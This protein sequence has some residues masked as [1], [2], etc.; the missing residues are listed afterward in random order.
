MTDYSTGRNLHID[1][2][3]SGIVIG[4][5]PTGFIADQLLPVLSVDKQSNIYFK[6]NHKEGR[7]FVPDL[8]RRAPGTAARKVGFSVSSDTYYAK[9]YALASDW[10]VEDEVNADEALGWAQMHALNV[11]DRL[12]IDYELRVAAM[13][14]TA[15]NVNTTFH[16]ATAWDNQTGSRPISDLQAQIEAFRQATGLRPNTLILPEQIARHVRINDQVRDLTFG[17]VVGGIADESHIARLLKIER[18]LVPEVLVNTFDVSDTLAGS[19]TLANGWANFAHLLY[20]NPLPGRMVDTWAQAFRWTNPM[21]GSPMAVQ[22]YPFDPK[23]K[24]Q[25]LEVS[26]YQDEKVVSTD[27]AWRM[28][29]VIA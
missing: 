19:A 21:F 16:V 1:A 5:R 14:N 10:P 25:G 24:T 27:L 2:V 3:L 7:Q 9:N 6:T 20:I 26:Y 23:L 4:R 12:L 22:R 28:D 18:V 8:S 17:N 11:T 29:S 13:A 15:A